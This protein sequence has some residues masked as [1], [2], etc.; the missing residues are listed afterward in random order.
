MFLVKKETSNKNNENFVMT[1][2]TIPTPIIIRNFIN[3][4]VNYCSTR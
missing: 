1:Y 2:A 4:G 3:V